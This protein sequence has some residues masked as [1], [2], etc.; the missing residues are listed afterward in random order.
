MTRNMNHVNDIFHLYELQ[1]EF[2]L[3]DDHND[4]QYG[5]YVHLEE[6]VNKKKINET[7]IIYIYIYICMYLLLTGPAFAVHLGLSHL[8]PQHDQKHE[9]LR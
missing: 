7:I 4:N 1:M 2:H 9:E 8:A 6:A 5:L 3:H